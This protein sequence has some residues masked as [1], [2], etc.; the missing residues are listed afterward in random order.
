MSSQPLRERARSGASP[1]AHPGRP[2]LRVAAPEA[3][4]AALSARIARS[5]RIIFAML[6]FL[7]AASV[8][9]LGASGSGVQRGAAALVAGM[10][11][12]AA[13]RLGRWQVT[14]ARPS[15]IARVVYRTR[16]LVIGMLMLGAVAHFVPWLGLEPGYVALTAGILGGV[17]A[18]WSLLTTRLLGGQYV[19]RTLLVGDGEQVGRFMR[20]FAADPHPAYQV[21]GLLTDASAEAGPLDGSTTLQQIVD[22]FDDQA[23]DCAGVPVL[24]SITDLETVL[25]AEAI[26]TVVVSVRRDRLD[27]FARLAA[28][29]GRITVQELPAFSEHVFGRVPIDVI[30]AAWFMHMIHPF[31]RRYSR[32]VKRAVDVFAAAVIGVLALPLL[33]LCAIAVK[34]TSPGPVFYSQVRIG[35]RGRT[36]RI[37]KFRTMCTDAEAAGAQWAQQND[38][39]VTSAGR[40]M[41]TTRLDELPQ[42]WN[43]LRG[44][45]SFVGPRPERPEFVGQLEAQLP[46]YQ[47]RHLVKPGLTGW[48]QVRHG[49]AASADDAAHKLGYELYYLKHQSLFLDLL[50]LMETVRVVVLRVG[51]R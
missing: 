6:A 13:F 2:S 26:D 23:I 39:R 47:R 9:V 5:A 28:W 27:L 30:N 46:Y 10:V 17:G 7:V 36:F 42:L 22:L 16:A 40:F 43:I 48:A 1:A 51:S 35:E 32:A 33:P 18:G 31:Y 38:P 20:E 29:D 37:H 41:R 12:V 8:M 19:H 3:P 44:Q 24:G 21:V 34:L 45:M 11:W 25:A 15:T 14:Y 4:D 50:V 49:Y